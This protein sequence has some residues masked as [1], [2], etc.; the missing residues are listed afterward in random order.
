MLKKRNSHKERPRNQALYSQSLHLR[1]IPSLSSLKSPKNSVKYFESGTDH[2]GFHFRNS[3][4]SNKN[5]FDRFIQGAYFATIYKP[6]NNSA[7]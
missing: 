6:R 4:L 1:T 5:T 2:K 7:R 3:G